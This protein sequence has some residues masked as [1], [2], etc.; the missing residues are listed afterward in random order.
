MP[1]IKVKPLSVNDAWQGK[2]FKT[3]KYK[4]YEKEVLLKLRPLEIPEGKLEIYLE[5]GFSNMGGDFG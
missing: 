5:W 4:A 1:E 3:D 2:R